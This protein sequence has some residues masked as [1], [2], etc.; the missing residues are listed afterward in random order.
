MKTRVF[1]SST[2]Y[3]LKQIRRDLEDFITS[4]G[5]EPVLSD[6]DNIAIPPGLDNIEACKWLVRNSDVFVLVIGGRYGTEDAETGKSITNIEYETAYD[7]GMP[8]YSFV[9]REVWAKR[10]T[11]ERLKEMILD[12]SL[13]KEKLRTALGKNIEDPRVFE[14]IDQI[15]TA[16]KDSWIHPFSKAQDIADYLK[17]NWSLL[18]RELLF[19]RRSQAKHEV[20]DQRTPKLRL[21]WI[22]SKG[23]TKDSLNVMWI[24]GVEKELTL[25]HLRKLMI[26]D[27]DLEI[28]EKQAKKLKEIPGLGTKN[29][30]PARR[31]LNYAHRI[32]ELLNI[33][34][35]NFEEYAWR[36]RIR[37]RAVVPV[38]DLVN[39][40]NAPASNIVVYLNSSEQ[41]VFMTEEELNRANIDVPDEVP[42]EIAKIVYLAKNPPGYKFPSYNAAIPN[43]DLRSFINPSLLN[44]PRRL[45]VGTEDYRLRIDI[46]GNL[47]HN[48]SQRVE[49]EGFYLCPKLRKGE[50]A[51]VEY[52]CHADNIASP[53]GG[54]LKVV[55][56]EAS[57]AKR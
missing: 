26:S 19:E 30:S 29:L 15:A 49:E 6:S 42:K 46:N 11:Y 2:C 24:P 33:A 16:K 38:L 37:D 27:E 51:E 31:V 40:G 17:N 52:E 3:D 7:T 12:E 5:Y 44:V 43:V 28:V 13:G 23:E 47:K 34:T 32:G 22:D 20:G 35:N 50:V 45:T 10:D 55:C 57:V 48:F 8:I 54:V 39:D 14:F 41:V 1:V 9:D 25:E 21:S 53:Q 4:M 18:F 36:Y 56:G